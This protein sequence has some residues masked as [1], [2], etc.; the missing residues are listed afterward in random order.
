MEKLTTSWKV[1]TLLIKLP[2]ISSII[3]KDFL[4]E[5]EIVEAMREYYEQHLLHISLE[6][7]EKAMV[8]E[9]GRQP[10]PVPEQQFNQDYSYPVYNE[11]G[12]YTD[13]AM[14]NT[15]VKMEESE[16]VQA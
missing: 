3:G 4:N 2:D 1:T 12:D 9:Q 13:D 6:N 16:Q 10:D 7:G 14:R 15:D 11:Y 8:T 5:P